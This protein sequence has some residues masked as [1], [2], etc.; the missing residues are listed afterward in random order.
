MQSLV[1]SEKHLWF[2]EIFRVQNL[3]PWLPSTRLVLFR[4]NFTQNNITNLQDKTLKDTWY[5]NNDSSKHTPQTKHKH[6]VKY[7]SIIYKNQTWEILSFL[8]KG[9]LGS[10]RSRISSSLRV[11]TCSDLS[12]SI[13]SVERDVRACGHQRIH[14]FRI[15]QR[16]LH[17]FCAL[18]WDTLFFTKK[19]NN[20]K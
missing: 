14:D 20:K 1:M 7:S 19:L 17:L 9:L 2:D 10:L 6:T 11:C 12:N 8:S 3:I 15:H 16:M 4:P 13:I 5:Q 18:C